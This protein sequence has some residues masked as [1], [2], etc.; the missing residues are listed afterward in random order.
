[1]FKENKAK[2]FFFSKNHLKFIL[3]GKIIPVFYMAEKHSNSV[4]LQNHLS[5]GCG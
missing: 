2:L 4:A 3:F 5:D 1:M